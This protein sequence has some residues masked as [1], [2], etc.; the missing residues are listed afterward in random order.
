M[1]LNP[2][3]YYKAIIEGLSQINP[4]EFAPLYDF[5]KR[6]E[7]KLV[8]LRH[9]ID[10]NP[11]MGLRMARH[12]TA[13]GIPSSFYL[14]PTASYYGMYLEAGFK[15]KPHLKNLIYGLI[16]AGCE[17]GL[18]NDAFRYGNQAPER[19]ETEIEWLRE[20][21]AIIRGTV[22]HCTLA[23][24]GA[25][26]YEIFKERVLFK[27]EIK[28]PLG[29]LS[30]EK[31]GLTYEGTFTTP[32]PNLTQEAISEY[33]DHMESSV[34]SEEW[35][36]RYLSENPYHTWNVDYQFWLIGPDEWI[37]SG[38]G[39]FEWRVPLTRVLS[40]IEGMPTDT[41]CLLVIH[42]DYFE[43]EKPCLEG[44]PTTTRITTAKHL[45]PWLVKHTPKRIIRAFWWAKRKRHE[46]QHDAKLSI[47]I[48]K[49]LQRIKNL[50]MYLIPVKTRWAK[51]QERYIEWAKKDLP[52]NY[53][54][55]IRKLGYRFAKFVGPPQTCLDIGTGNGLYGGMTYD[56]AEYRY[57][58]HDK[59][60]QVVGLD[61][62]PLEAPM[63]SWTNHYITAVCEHLPLRKV[64]DK[65]TIATSFDHLID[66]RR[67]LKECAAALKGP[68]FIWTTCFQ[69]NGPDEFHPRTFTKNGMLRI[70]EKTGFETQRLIVA[71]RTK[72]QEIVFIEARKGEPPWA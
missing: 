28:L 35:M 44:E 30:E 4:V 32:K 29:T 71:Q 38:K 58:D 23:S 51:T 31:L 3:S 18:H 57:L 16:V 68:L 49:R 2:F 63:P 27:R 17:I 50:S 48:G 67:S 36:R 33:I 24:F 55:D 15:R 40:I 1:T 60:S 59:E 39:G 19:V 25:E 7:L 47:W 34:Q 10:S 11:W 43:P 5:D 21:G 9:D 37:A 22:P 45:R 64:F 66:H 42:P 41:R 20:Q 6:S 53:L 12:L 46:L 72:R 70:L 14:L 52:E 8:G 65:I 61:P 54:N 69:K 56:E 62:L 26:N 13:L